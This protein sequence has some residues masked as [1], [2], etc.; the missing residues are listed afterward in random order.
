[1]VRLSQPVDGR[2]APVLAERDSSPASDT[3]A[4]EA[5]ITRRLANGRPFALLV[6]DM[7]AL[8]DF[9]RDE[10]FAAG[11]D[12]L[13]RLADSLANALGPD[14]DVARVGSDEFAILASGQSSDSAAQL[15]TRLERLLQTTARRRPWAGPPTRRRATTRSRSTAQR[16][17]AST[18]AR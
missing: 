1:M 9:N 2:R 14:D 15:A 10:G 13:R 11:N 12:A 16:A 17:S 7:D 18:R 4:F 5:A 6:A 8:K 3:R